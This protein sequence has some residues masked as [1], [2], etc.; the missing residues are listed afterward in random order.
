LTLSAFQK[1]NALKINLVNDDLCS[2]LMQNMK[3][4][5]FAVEKSLYEN[6]RWAVN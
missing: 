4:A 1:V 2:I 6:H 5:N 3:D